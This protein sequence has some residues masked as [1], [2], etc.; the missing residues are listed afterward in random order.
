MEG[1]EGRKLGQLLCEHRR[2][3][4]GHRA[5]HD[6]LALVHLL[7]QPLTLGPTG[8]ELMMREAAEVSV[9]GWATA[10]PYER[11]ALLK[12]RGYRWASGEGRTPRAGWRD[13]PEA[14]VDAEVLYLR[15]HVYGDSGAQPL[16][17]QIKSLERFSVRADA[18]C[19]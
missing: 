16:C 17:R 19:R 15:E 10:A 7:Q 2:F 11:K 6:V 8:F 4:D 14:L 12:A 1:F 9:R 3:L 5:L 18:P 13:V